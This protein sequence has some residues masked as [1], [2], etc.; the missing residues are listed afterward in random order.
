MK[1]MILSVYNV[2][3]EDT[4]GILGN[5]DYILGWSFRKAVGYFMLGFG[6]GMIFSAIFFAVMGWLK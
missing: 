5:I 4:M 3:W 2:P 6:V 1:V